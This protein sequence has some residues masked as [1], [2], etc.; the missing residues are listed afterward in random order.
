MPT[1][2]SP[3][4]T[5]VTTV[6]EGGVTFDVH[7]QECGPQQ[8]VEHKFGAWHCP[9]HRDVGHVIFQARIADA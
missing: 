5:P 8:P 9:V 6:V 3:V 4:L 1:T 7:C 2:T